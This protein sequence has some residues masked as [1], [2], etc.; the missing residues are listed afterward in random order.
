M[1]ADHVADR[2]GLANRGEELVAEPLALEAPL[3]SPAMSWKSIVSWTTS[4]EPQRLRDPL[5]PLVGNT[6]DGHVR[7]DVVNG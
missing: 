7:L 1:G 5:D 2:V 6:D 3:T 4:D